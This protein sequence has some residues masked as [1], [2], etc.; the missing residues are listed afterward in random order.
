MTRLVEAL[1]ALNLYAEIDLA[2]RWV[3]LQGEQCA[4]YV[5]A[6]AW[7]NGYVTW[8]EDGTARVVE[9][10]RDPIE[11]IQVGLRRAA[12]PDGERNDPENACAL[13]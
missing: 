8:C 5:V 4:V 7:D 3:K 13:P 10:Y 11:A 6:A 9:R 2:G 12:R 1:L